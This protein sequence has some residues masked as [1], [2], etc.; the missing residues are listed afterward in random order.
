MR[1]LTG[2][3]SDDVFN[4]CPPT[5]GWSIGEIVHHLCILGEQLLPR[6]DVGIDEARSYGW[7]NPGPFRYP[8]FSRWF[9]RAVG[10]LPASKRGKMKAPGL[11]VPKANHAMDEILPRFDKLQTDLIARCERAD[12]IDIAR[13]VIASPAAAWI[14]VR[15]GAWIEAIAAH[16]L[17]HF[18]QIEETR[19]ALGTALQTE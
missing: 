9:I 6:I 12:G 1:A 4:K 2:D 14:R 19:E 7:H 3:L 17:R 10:P 16:Q 11:Y 18:A 5:G 8:F 15:L 13:V